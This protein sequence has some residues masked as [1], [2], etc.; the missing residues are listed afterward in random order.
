LIQGAR[1]PVIVSLLLLVAI[2]SPIR[3][4][5]QCS[6]A[7][8]PRSEQ[9]PP[10]ANESLSS[11]TVSANQQSS[12]VRT[13]DPK[14]ERNAITVPENTS[15]RVMSNQPISS[16]M[17]KPGTPLSFTVNQDV[18]IDGLLVIP[19]GAIVRGSIVNT[20][21]AGMLTGSTQL[22]FELSALELGGQSYPLYTYQFKVAGASKT[23]PTKTKIK[24]GAV[25]G[26]IVM[27]AGSIASNHT[28]AHAP[29]A[30]V[31]GA[32]LGAGVGTAVAAASPA[33]IVSI[34]AESEM[35]FVLSSPVAVVPVDA[36]EAARLAR[37]MKPGGPVLYI[38]DD[39]Q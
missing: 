28:T 9:A 6:Q 15:L 8:L 4:S 12:E 37:G 19:C 11:S 21:K 23:A 35:V 36:K 7:Q 39:T 13:V 17:T 34:P 33:P 1:N 5:A 22:E 2:S 24:T 16:R 14:N 29:G 38:R 27:M 3:V 31:T 25:A 20:Q 18:N 26:A 10:R 30:A 32:A